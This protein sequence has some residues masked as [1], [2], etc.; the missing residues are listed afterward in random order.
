MYDNGVVHYMGTD[1]CYPFITSSHDDYPSIHRAIADDNEYMGTV[2]L[3]NIDNEN[4]DAEF[5]ITACKC[6]MGR[7]YSKYSMDEIICFVY[8]QLGLKTIYYYVSEENIR[9]IRL[10]EK[11][12]Y[13]QVNCNEFHMCREIKQQNNFQRFVIQK[14]HCFTAEGCNRFTNTIEYRVSLPVFCR[15]QRNSL[16]A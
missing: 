15:E 2:S 1:F 9:V 13:E 6:A 5:G 10:H 12:G 16:T 8:E 14:S 7:G 11:N 4:K 3:K